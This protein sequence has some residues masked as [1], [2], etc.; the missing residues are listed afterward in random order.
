MPS[1]WP[2]LQ[3]Q[4]QKPGVFGHLSRGR[5]QKLRKVRA[6]PQAQLGPLAKSR[7]N[8]GFLPLFCSP[9]AKNALPLD[10]RKSAYKCFDCA[11]N[12]FSHH[13][14]TNAQKKNAPFKIDAPQSNS[15]YSDNRCCQKV[16]SETGM[17]VNAMDNTK[18]SAFEFMIPRP[19][20]Q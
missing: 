7:K 5:T 18:N 16:K 9:K 12:Q 6:A 1:F 13:D 15:Q 11:V 20:H 4:C 19:S 2:F 10:F 8:S 14:A 3:A 17:P